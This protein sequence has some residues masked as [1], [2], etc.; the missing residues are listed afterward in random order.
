MDKSPYILKINIRKNKYNVKKN[1]KLDFSPKSGSEFPYDPKIWNEDYQTKNSHN[2]YSYALGKI[3]KKLKSKAQP[4]YS[5]AH[6]HIELNNYKCS[7]FLKRLKK[8]APGSHLQYFDK[9]C[10]N[11]FYK[12]FL[13][14]DKE[15]DYHWYRQDS[16][17]FWSHK[18]GS[19][20]V[21]N[22]DADNKKIK[23]PVKANRDY[24]MLNYKTP[25]FFACIYSDLA[26]AL[27]DIYPMTE[28]KSSYFFNNF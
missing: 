25:C 4:G 15:N 7:S 3:V 11:G 10:L 23:N 24:G 14:L 17:G 22:L 20:K 28:K 2:C 12:I 1:N 8:D 18:P 5:S 27:D 13:T 16:N 19:S 9:P 21:T 26:R 6:D